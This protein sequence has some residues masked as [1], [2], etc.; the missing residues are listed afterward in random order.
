MFRHQLRLVRPVARQGYFIR[1]IL[2]SALLVAAGCGG[3]GGSS[4]DEA[5]ISAALVVG[6]SVEQVS[7]TV[8]SGSEVILNGENSDGTRFPIQSATWVQTD[9]SGLTIQL[10]KRTELTRVFRV[11]SVD[12]NTTLTFELTIVNTD[13]DRSVTEVTVNVVRLGD[14]DQFLEYFSAIPGVYSVIAA[15]KPGFTITSDAPLTIT[16]SALVNYADRTSNSNTP[17]QF[18]LPIGSQE[19]RTTSWLSGSVGTWQTTQEAIDAYYNPNFCF[20]IP[21]LDLDDINTQFDDTNPDAGIDEYRV[22]SVEHF[23]QLTLEVNG[24][25]CEDGS[26]GVVDCNDAVS[27]I[28]IDANGD[29][30]DPMPGASD[31]ARTLAVD[32][33]KASTDPRRL[34]ESA[35]TAAAYYRAVDPLNRR[36]TLEDWLVVAGITDAS[37]Q[38]IAPAGELQHTTYVNNYDLGFTRDMFVRVDP[39]NGNVYA[40][41]NN[42]AA[43]RPAILRNADPNRPD[44]DVIA[45]VVMEYTPAEQDPDGPPVVDPDQKFTKFFV[46]IPDQLGQGSQV[47]VNSLNFD[48]RGEKWVP[49]ACTPCHGGDTRALSPFNNELVYPFHGDLD[50][51]F[52]PWDLDSLLYVDA[53][54]PTQV[55]PLVTQGFVINPGYLSADQ[56]AEFSRENQEAAFRV[57]NEAVLTTMKD[58]SG[59]GRFDVIR[60]LI[61]GWYGNLD[62][63]GDA[64]DTGDDL[65]DVAFDGSFI[66]NGWRESTTGVAGL[67]TFY[68]D[69]FARHCR[70]CHNQI[71]TINQ[72]GDWASFEQVKRLISQY[73]FE[74]G[75]MP[76][77]RLDMDRFWVD[78]HGD[79]PTAAAQLATILG[80]TD[81]QLTD[82]PGRPVARISNPPIIAALAS[83]TEATVDASQNEGAVRLDGS[84]SVFAEAFSWTLTDSASQPTTGAFL[85]NADTAKPAVRL[86]S[87]DMYTATLTVSDTLSDGSVLTDSIS[88]TINAMGN[89]PM[90]T[91]PAQ[92]FM[93]S[94]SLPS[95]PTPSVAPITQAHLE[96]TDLDT[97]DPSMITYNVTS[98][99]SQGVLSSN[100]FSQQDINDNTLTYTEGDGISESSSNDLFRYSVSDADGNTIDL[101]IFEI[102]VVLRNDFPVE[103]SNG[104]LFAVEATNATINT[105]T[106]Q[107]LDQDNPATDV[108]YIVGDVPVFGTLQLT[109]G[110]TTSDLNTGAT[111]TQDDID[112][113]RISYDNT[114]QSTTD[115][116][117][118][119]V[120]DNEITVPLTPSTS[121]FAINIQLLTATPT[122]TALDLDVPADLENSLSPDVFVVDSDT[123]L[124]DVTVTLTGLPANGDI[125]IG[126]TPPRTILLLNDTFSA[127]QIAQV[128]YVHDGPITNLTPDS[129]TLRASDGDSTTAN[130]SANLNIVIV[131]RT[132]NPTSQGFLTA[133]LD[134]YLGAT[135]RSGAQAGWKD[136]PPWNSVSMVGVINYVAST[137]PPDPGRCSNI[138]YTVTSSPA[139]G[140]LLLSGVPV[141]A[142]EQSDVVNL[143]YRNLEFNNT[144]DSFDIVA[145]DCVLTTPGTVVITRGMNPISDVGWV[146]DTRWTDASVPNRACRDCHTSAGSAATKPFTNT[147][148]E[149]GTIMC[150]ELQTRYTSP[151]AAGHLLPAWP[152]N[153]T[154]HSGGDV[155]GDATTNPRIVLQQWQDEGFPPATGCP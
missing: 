118:Y 18:D 116:F 60:P 108:T 115:S 51:A 138:Q 112:S 78:F 134:G 152:G 15:L 24:G 128:F 62:G 32:T 106:L 39:T 98:G 41:V 126:A 143:V 11:P 25:T 145:S 117:S 100:T 76:N 129:I 10:D 130:S 54:D 83:T 73:V 70:I 69:V 55:D 132:D 27:L 89:I 123:V 94:E 19:I 5:P 33:L 16:Q 107:W 105:S 37:G 68:T 47:R 96:W 125:A 58:S 141:T 84:I 77:A 36:T 9:N 121:P 80:I 155:I 6:P 81:P 74:D 147:L 124:A 63:N 101:Q 127:D 45:T 13:G 38:F 12:F 53:A 21:K 142:F 1:C 122:I 75:V 28:V 91:L 99:P 139:L 86:L 72:F 8:R 61:H 31:T 65:P 135:S 23:V 43:L 29:T 14:A 64:Q 87:E 30:V 66:P 2:A 20:T 7:V 93:I 110:A 17:N 26:G 154:T 56:L 46:Y 57:M 131:A 90:Q 42:F 49:G 150:T 151:D 22:D 4:R 52:L 133:D 113:G 137:T 140:E 44:D 144:S 103:N 34:P 114:S 92:M 40:Y 82:G 104:P 50:A 59:S 48:G 120:T 95:D 119:T 153:G 67:D 79:S 71:K 35:A 88:V 85:T 109:V 148:A 97:T 146:I 111:F 149:G 3:G 102:G 136:T